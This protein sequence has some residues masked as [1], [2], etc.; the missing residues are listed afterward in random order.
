M[1]LIAERGIAAHY[2]GKA[3]PSMLGQNTPAGRNSRG[4]TT[5]LKNS[6]FALRVRR[7]YYISIWNHS[8]KHTVIVFDN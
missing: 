7:F 4:K 3:V 8:N 5:C 2:S 1:D 6:D